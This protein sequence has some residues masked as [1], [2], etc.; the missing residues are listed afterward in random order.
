[1]SVQCSIFFTSAN[2]VAGNSKYHQTGLPGTGGEKAEDSMFRTPQVQ[3]R[4]TKPLFKLNFNAISIP[5]LEFL[6]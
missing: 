5:S 4:L 6:T 1:M 2:R 3:S